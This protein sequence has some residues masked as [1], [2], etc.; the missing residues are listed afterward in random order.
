MSY[1][2][3]SIRRKGRKGSLLALMRADFLTMMPL[4]FD[5]IASDNEWMKEL[6]GLLGGPGVDSYQ[7]HGNLRITPDGKWM[8]GVLDE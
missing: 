1:P 6:R 7:V 3:P 8:N 4:G 2:P 5:S